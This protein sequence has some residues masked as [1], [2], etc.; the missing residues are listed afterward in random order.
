[1]LDDQEEEV[2]YIVEVDFPEGMKNAEKVRVASLVYG[3]PF[4]FKKG[5]KK[6][7]AHISDVMIKG[8]MLLCTLT[9]TDKDLEDNMHDLDWVLRNYIEV[10]PI[11]SL[12]GLPN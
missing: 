1:M 7:S 2:P 4:L 3:N 10:D 6:S 9:F 8:Q 5:S 12:L 11:S